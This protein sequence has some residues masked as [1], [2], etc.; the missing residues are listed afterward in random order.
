MKALGA[1][2]RAAYSTLPPGVQLIGLQVW[3]P[4]L[5]VILFC[6]CYVF[7]F[8]APSPHNVPVAVVGSSQAAA[9]FAST[10]ESDS[11]GMFA[12]TLE[13]SL[14]AA[15]TDVRS[16]DV[17]AAYVPAAAVPDDP[18]APTAEVIVASAAQ[19]QLSV[20]ATQY[21]TPVAAAE[22][23]T[24]S[25]QDLAPLPPRDSFGTGLFYLTLVSLIGG[26]MIAMFV[27]LMG[28]PLKHRQRIGII[29]GFSLLLP[30]ISTLLVR[31]VIGVVDQNFFAIWMIGAGT[32]FAVG[33]VVNGLS[34][35]TGRF[36]TGLALGLFVFI[37][38]PASGGAFPPE[39]MPQPFEFLHPY[40]SATGTIDLL[41][42]TVYGVGP[43]LAAGWQILAGYAIV[44]AIL[45][46]IGKPY[47]ERR[48]ARR[49][50]KGMPISMLASAQAAAAALAVAAT[51]SSAGS[52]ARNEGPGS[53]VDAGE[54]ETDDVETDT[55]SISA[56]V[57]SGV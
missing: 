10:L 43:G 16:G 6:F 30:L 27:G 28:G 49:A 35:F 36:V 11:N 55:H 29:A 5:F 37:N 3:L 21:F 13:P 2:Y 52:D 7:A 50:E 33:L 44:G 39:F 12:V 41:R 4:V 53:E 31:F 19:Y 14:E 22:G 32:A 23:A 17:A 34:Y 46:A 56:A 48:A 40:V 20:L 24:L 15:Q 54:A 45:T 51:P 18:G 8:H 9:D 38:I 26:Y 57:G 47:A 1:R 25:V 42:E